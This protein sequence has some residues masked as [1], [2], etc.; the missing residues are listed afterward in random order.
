MIDLRFFFQAFSQ[1]MVLSTSFLEHVISVL[2]QAS[3]F[4]GDLDR[5]EDSQVVD[6]QT[7]DGLLQAAILA[8]TAFFRSVLSA[9]PNWIQA[10]FY[11]F[12][13]YW[14][15]CWCRGGGKIGKRAVEQNYASVISELMLQ[16]G[17]CHGIANS[18]QQEPLR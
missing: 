1:H 14:A 10:I 18:G 2:S 9:M 13:V 7:E 3:I 12:T 5:A 16:L 11:D 15:S 6:S 8:L 4:K 17:S